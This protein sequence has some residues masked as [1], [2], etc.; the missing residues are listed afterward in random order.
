MSV[1]HDENAVRLRHKLLVSR[2]PRN[3]TCAGLNAAMSQRHWNSN[4]S[5]ST[6]TASDAARLMQQTRC[7]RRCSSCSTDALPLT[8]LVLFNRHVA[9][10]AARLA[11][12]TR[13][14]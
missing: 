12:Q 10:A 14:L 9:S 3:T 13:C 11:Q 5:Y 7:L 6:D 8:L 4:V 1:G 2:F